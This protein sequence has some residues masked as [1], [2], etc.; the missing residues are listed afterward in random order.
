MRNDNRWIP[1]IS[2]KKMEHHLAEDLGLKWMLSVYITWL[3]YKGWWV[4][5]EG[6]SSALCLRPDVSTSLRLPLLF[7][8]PPNARTRAHGFTPTLLGSLPT[9]TLPLLPTLF[10]DQH[11]RLFSGPCWLSCSYLLLVRTVM[12]EGQWVLAVQSVL[13]ASQWELTCCPFPSYFIY[14]PKFQQADCSVSHLP[15]LWFPSW[16]IVPPWR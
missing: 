12:C 4:L 5:G 1:I 3:A 10:L 14:N 6:Q 11:R 8:P 7:H 16:F 9:A 2:K 13:R 15:S